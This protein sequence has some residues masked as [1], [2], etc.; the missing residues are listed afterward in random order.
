[1]ENFLGIIYELERV[2]KMQEY[3]N[4]MGKISLTKINLLSLKFIRFY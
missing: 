3:S 4:Y 2:E 1:M